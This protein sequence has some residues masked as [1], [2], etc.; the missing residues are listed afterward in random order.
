MPAWLIVLLVLGVI[1]FLLVGCVA[2][3][4]NTI[5]KAVEETTNGFNDI[6]GKT[7]FSLNETFQNKYEKITMKEVNLDFK[8]YNEY[9]KPAAGNKYIMV[10]FEVE[11][12]GEN[13]ELYVSS[14]S[15]VASADGETY[16]EKYIGND[17]YKDVTATVGPKK[18]TTGYVFYEVPKDAKKIV[19]DYNANFWTD[20]TSI[21]FIVK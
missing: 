17:K 14:L 8:D 3:C 18:K 4:T 7:S 19:I 6:N 15:F 10:K 16:N 1:F 13:D 12:I 20:G 2:G 11:N 9:L 21:E 5:N